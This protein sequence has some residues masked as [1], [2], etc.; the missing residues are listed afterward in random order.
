M[1]RFCVEKLTITPES[2]KPKK[3]RKYYESL[4]KAGQAYDRAKKKAKFNE[5]IL[6]LDQFSNQ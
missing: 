2:Q 5:L 4:F 6:L 3:T 1:K